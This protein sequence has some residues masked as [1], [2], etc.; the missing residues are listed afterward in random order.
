MKKPSIDVARAAVAASFMALG[1]IAALAPAAANAQA[2]YPSKPIRLFIPFTPGGG[3][4]F[5]SRVVA[6]KLS[7]TLKWQVVPENK[8]GASG[9]LAIAEAARA[10]PD[11]YTIVM[12]QSDNMMLGPYLFAN[13]GYDTVQ[14]FVPIVQVSEAPLA[15]VSNA[16]PPAGQVKL[17]KVSDM[18]A[19]G[20]TPEQIEQQLMQA[21]PR[22]HWSEA[23]HLLIHHGRNLCRARNPL[24]DACPLQSLCL[25][26][27][28]LKKA[29]KRG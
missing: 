6:S 4:D 1:A 29:A 14:S 28:S 20:K 16:A 8:P 9:N 11:G 12:G 17:A 10:A 7:E 13:V 15:I 3:T 23:H 19:K 24:C 27:A 18:V 5:V 26:F 25:Y 2:D 21:I 22:Q